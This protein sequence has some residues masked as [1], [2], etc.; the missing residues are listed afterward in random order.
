M[1]ILLF[2]GKTIVGTQVLSMRTAHYEMQKKDLNIIVSSYRGL[3]LVESKKNQELLSQMEAKY[4]SHLFS[5]DGSKSDV[6]LTID[7][8]SNIL[9]QKWW[10]QFPL[11]EQCTA[12][13][14][15]PL[16]KKIPIKHT[17]RFQPS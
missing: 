4:L 2:L 3:M 9:L 13:C 8:F 17:F 7:T 14:S 10:V 15:K 12:Q 6:K 11:S 1:W 5:K 16:H